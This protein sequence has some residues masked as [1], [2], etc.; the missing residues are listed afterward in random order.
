MADKP[1]I[2]NLCN[3]EMQEYTGPKYSKKLGGF[4]VLAGILSTLFWVGA[5]LGI[6][7]LIIGLY[8]AGAKRNLWVC[9]ECNTAIERIDLK[10]K[11]LPK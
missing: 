3:G 10:T 2:C 11:I 6:P 4:L 7:L 1:L 8:M 5:V 9:K